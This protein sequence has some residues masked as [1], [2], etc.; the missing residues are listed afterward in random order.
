M[1]VGREVTSGPAENRDV[2]FLDRVQHVT[3]VSI[4]V[5]QWRAFVKH[6]ALNTAAE[7]FDEIAVEFL[8]DVTDHPL[9]VNLDAPVEKP[10]EARRLRVGG[11]RRR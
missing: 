1:I 5:G 2:E 9:G 10:L 8:I 6:A 3:P 11:D 7:M 4:G